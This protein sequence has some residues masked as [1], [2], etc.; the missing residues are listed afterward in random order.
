MRILPIILFLPCIAMGAEFKT[1]SEARTQLDAVMSAVVKDDIRGAF[2]NLKPYWVGMPEA[3]IEVMI[4]KVA[5]QLP[6]LE[7]R[8]GKPIEAKFVLQKTGAESVAYFMYIEKFEKHLL[9]W[10]FY[11]YKPHDSWQIN[12]VNF[13]DRIQGV[14]D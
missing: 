5:D 1:L 13:D 6:L 11:L 9:R 7:S 4:S 14:V 12:S 10:H 2:G 3:E 8:Y